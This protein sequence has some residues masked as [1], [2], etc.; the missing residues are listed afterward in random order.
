MQHTL[1][2]SILISTQ[3]NKDFQKSVVLIC[4]ASKVGVFGLQINGDLIT[5][6]DDTTMY[7]GGP[8]NQEAVFLLHSMDE[9][10]NNEHLLVCEENFGVTQLSPETKQYQHEY[11]HCLTLGGYLFWTLPQFKNE[12]KHMK[13]MVGNCETD[14]I[15]ST[16]NKAK[17]LEALKINNFQL[18]NLTS[19]TYSI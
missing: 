2:G 12:I 16:P 8:N 19:T 17:W 14:L 10:V 3:Y 6:E 1:T 9:N 15:F 5:T 11:S 18:S 13:W 4:D 7:A